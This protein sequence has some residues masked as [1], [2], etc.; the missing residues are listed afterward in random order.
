[1]ALAGLWEEW[2]GAD[3]TTLQTC[4]IL[5]GSSNSLIG[6]IHDRMATIVPE[7]HYQDWLNPN[8]KTDYLLAILTAP[9]LAEKMKVWKVSPQVNSVRNQG[10]EL[11]LPL[12]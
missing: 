10:A 9:Y 11:I 1:M 4:T 6:K 5:V 8:E 7:N 3:G 2:K 12:T